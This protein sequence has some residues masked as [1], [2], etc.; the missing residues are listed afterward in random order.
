MRI[1]N[2]SKTFQRGA[3][4]V[5]VV[6][7]LANL[8]LCASALGQVTIVSQDRIVEGTTNNTN[9]DGSMS[10]FGPTQDSAP[11]GSF[12]D[13]ND[14][15]SLPGNLT[16]SGN[17]DGGFDGVNTFSIT[18]FGLTIGGGGGPDSAGTSTGTVRY[19]YTFQVTQSST[20]TL[21]GLFGSQ[22]PLLASFHLTGPGVSINN[23]SSSGDIVFSNTT[24]AMSPGTY[25]LTAQLSGTV[26]FVGPGGNGAGSGASPFTLVISPSAC[27]PDFDHDGHVAVADIFAFLNAWFAGDPRADFSGNGVLEVADIFAFLN[28]WFAGC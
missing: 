18:S 4:L 25:T 21:N 19:S 10:T 27:A 15:L 1:H 2:S 23:D 28:A 7:A 3:C 16:V 11:A 17:Q 9:P 8:F 20:Y 5:T 22:L 6:G 24:G 12:G 26:A 13:W 14:S